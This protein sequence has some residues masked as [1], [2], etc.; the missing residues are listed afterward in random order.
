QRAVG[1]WVLAALHFPSARRPASVGPVKAFVVE[2]MRSTGLP[3]GGRSPPALALPKPATDVSPLR[4][5]PIT[6]AGTLVS[7]KSTVPV[8]SVTSSSNLSLAYAEDGDTAPATHKVA[9][10]IPTKSNLGL[11]SIVSPSESQA[12]DRVSPFR[13]A[14]FGAAQQP[15]LLEALAHKRV[16]AG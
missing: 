2:P 4:T 12:V 9:A 3:F 7:K 5:A 13:L 8:K 14:S 15:R 11:V 6:T 1:C 10:N 16:A